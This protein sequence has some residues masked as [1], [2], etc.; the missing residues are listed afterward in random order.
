[1]SSLADLLPQVQELS[2][3]DKRQL[4]KFLENSL[5]IPKVEDFFVEGQE[6]PIWSPYNCYEAAETLM[7]LLETKKQND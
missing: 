2:E 7:N 3:I 6:Y 4:L 5:L 1:M